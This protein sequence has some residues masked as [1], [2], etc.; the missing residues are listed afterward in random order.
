MAIINNAMNTE[1]A[2]RKEKYIIIPIY[3][4]CYSISY[5]TGIHCLWE[6]FFAVPCPGCGFTRAVLCMLR[7]DF[8]KAWDYHPMYWSAF[9]IVL[10][11]VF[12]GEIFKNQAANK[13]TVSIVLSGFLIVWFYRLSMGIVV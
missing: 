12:E 10:L 2:K 5:L 11:F 3:L 13:V 7:F 6:H 1:K 4:I 8:R 9:L